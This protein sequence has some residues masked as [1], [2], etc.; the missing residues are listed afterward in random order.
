MKT[1]FAGFVSS[2]LALSACSRP[3]EPAPGTAS[4]AIE[5][6][7]VVLSNRS[8]EVVHYVVVEEQESALIDLDYD[9]TRWP[10]LAPSEV[11]RIAYGDIMGYT[12]GAR[13]VRIYWWSPSRSHSFVVLDL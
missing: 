9:P 13:Q 6:G 3:T 12:P 4:A 7:Y 1:L 2:L 10:A 8:S 5:A 11:K